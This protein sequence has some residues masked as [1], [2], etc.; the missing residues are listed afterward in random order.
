MPPCNRG[1]M[2]KDIPVCNTA[3]QHAA[4]AHGYSQQY[5][6]PY[7]S[8]YDCSQ[9][10]GAKPLANRHGETHLEKRTMYPCPLAAEYGCEQEFYRKD[11]AENHA[12]NQHLGIGIRHPCPEAARFSC[13]ADFVGKWKAAQHAKCHTHPIRCSRLGCKARFETVEDAWA[14][15]SSP[16]HVSTSKLFVCTVPMCPDSCGWQTNS[17]GRRYI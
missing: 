17:R 9:V 1:E 4:A 5:Q 13:Q 3:M 16:D 7:A 8:E 12:D 6:C 14:H 15:E 10:F 11:A 2:R